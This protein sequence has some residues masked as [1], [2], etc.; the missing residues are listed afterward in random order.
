MGLKIGD[1]VPEFTLKN[2]K[3]E[4]FYS[5]HFIG[6]KPMVIYFYPKDNTPGCTK[7]ACA[8][9][10]S[11]EDFT[12]LGAEVIGVSSDTEKSHRRF[13]E[14]NNLPF[15]LLADKGNKVRKMFKVESNL[16]VLPGRETYV[17]DTS[18]EIILVFNSINAN[19]H[20]KKALKALKNMS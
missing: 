20:M 16:W 18:G 12:A 3:G 15:T 6:R 1:R 9:R 4:D 2:Q 7:E 8:F 19:L 10:D 11:Y 13:A 14:K 17:V 5:A